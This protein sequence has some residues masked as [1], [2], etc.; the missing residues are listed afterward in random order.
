[1]NDTVA[2]FHKHHEL[3]WDQDNVQFVDKIEQQQD[4]SASLSSRFSME[5]K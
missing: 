2:E 4:S 5:N 1:M 3:E